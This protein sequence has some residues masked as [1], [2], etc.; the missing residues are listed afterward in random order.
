MNGGGGG[1]NIFWIT[2]LFL[3]VCCC[4]FCFFLLTLTI[5]SHSWEAMF[6]GEERGSK[7]NWQNK[8]PLLWRKVFYAVHILDAWGQNNMEAWGKTIPANFKLL[9]LL[10]T[11]VVHQDV[12]ASPALFGDE[13]KHVFNLITFRHVGSMVMDLGRP[14]PTALIH[15]CRHHIRS[16]YTV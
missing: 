1:E 10:L 9:K 15:G 13:S 6:G 16:I 11:S 5:L 8:V 12:R 2:N 14:R 4:F 3:F 7:I